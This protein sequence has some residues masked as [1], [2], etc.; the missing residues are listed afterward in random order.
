MD[1]S[2]RLTRKK[3]VDF[4]GTIFMKE[5]HERK[6]RLSCSENS[7]ILFF[8]K[9]QNYYENVFILNPGVGM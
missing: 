2:H 6:M 4:F 7:G 8:K 9:T 3:G 5:A 1:E